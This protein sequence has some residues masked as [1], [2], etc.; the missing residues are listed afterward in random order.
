MFLFIPGVAA[1]VYN[2]LNVDLSRCYVD[3]TGG[4]IASYRRLTPPYRST[5]VSKSSTLAIVVVVV[6][7]FKT[8]TT[9]YK[10]IRIF[11]YTQYLK[12]QTGSR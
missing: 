4:R 8:L 2:N 1:R 6:L 11:V 9:L 12:G 5:A 3:R 10:Y 7:L